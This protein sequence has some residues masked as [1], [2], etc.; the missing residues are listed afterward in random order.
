MSKNIIVSV[1]PN[2]IADIKSK[3]TKA[4]HDRNKYLNTSKICILTAKLRNLKE[5]LC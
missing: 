4:E 3:L 2:T 5:I 1:T